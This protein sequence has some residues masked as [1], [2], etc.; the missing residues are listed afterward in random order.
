MG[1]LEITGRSLSRAGAAPRAAPSAL[2]AEAA[3][4]FPSLEGPKR[5]FALTTSLRCLGERRL[6]PAGRR[7]SSPRRQGAPRRVSAATGV[8]P[9]A[10]GG[11]RQVLRSP[12]ADLHMLAARSRLCYRFSSHE[13]RLR[14]KSRLWA[15]LCDRAVTSSAGAAQSSSF[16]CRT[17]SSTKAPGQLTCVG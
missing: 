7:M 4:P 12:E 8:S 3:M 14:D 15:R 2:P 1:K 13:P 11:L 9:R 10:R 6:S 17:L 5:C 16:S